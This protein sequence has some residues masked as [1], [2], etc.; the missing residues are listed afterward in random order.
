MRDKSEAS[1]IAFEYGVNK[2]DGDFRSSEMRQMHTR[3]LH[4]NFAKKMQQFY[5]YTDHFI[6]E[7]I[8][9]F[10]SI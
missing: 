5:K 3:F 6:L 4:Y 2:E 1:G 8:L 10:F 7:S 9:N